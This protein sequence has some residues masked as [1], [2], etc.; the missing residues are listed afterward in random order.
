MLSK[1]KRSKKNNQSNNKNKNI[2]KKVN[3]AV[4]EVAVKKEPE[5]NNVTP[6]PKEKAPL[7]PFFFRRFFEFLLTSLVISVPLEA[8]RYFKAPTSD[9]WGIRLSFA[10]CVLFVILNIYLFRVF[11]FSIGNKKVYFR[12]NILAYTLF[13]AINMLSVIYL[14]QIG[15][16]DLHSFVFMP[17]DYLAYLMNDIS[18][19]SPGYEFF[20]DLASKF[21]HLFMYILIF[22]S[23]LEM[24][25][26]EKQI[27]KNRR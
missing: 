26:I 11:F 5:K 13:A 8:L 16:E 14:P 1:K 20:M 10:A 6:E 19:A 15:F 7:F 21:M 4:K 25:A 22:A 18:K 9:V 2:E 24:Y 23:P 17:A 3:K 27:K 12:V